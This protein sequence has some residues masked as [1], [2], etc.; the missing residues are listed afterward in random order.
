MKSSLI[1]VGKALRYNLPFLTYI[2]STISKH[3]T[4]PDQ[5]VYID[6]NDK[7]LF[8]VLEESIAHADEIVIV[9]SNDSFNLVNKV[10]A[11][12]GEETLEVKEGML[13]P[14]KTVMFEPNSY[15]LERS[16]KRINVIKATENKK[17]PT[18]LIDNKN[19]SA[20]FSIINIDEDSLKILLEPLAQNYEIRITPTTIIDGWITVEAVSNKYGNLESFFKAAKSLLPQKVI[21][22]P[23]VI[24]HIASCLEAHGK[25]L[26]IAE[27]CTGGLI[28]SMLTE[29][30]GVSAV[31]KGGLVAYANEIKTSWLGVSEETIERHGA[32]SELCIREMLEG[33]LN[34]SLSDYAVATS[35]IAGPT[36]GTVEKPVGTVYVGARNKEGDVFIERLLLEGDRQYIQTQSAYH[37]FKLLLHV[38][39]NIFLK[40]EKNS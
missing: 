17:L 13:I 7:D 9:T 19:E 1:V 23:D 32:V 30:S 18:I 2:H 35:G 37:A 40:S 4:L 25:T 3:L 27:S 6:K 34:A 10:I 14:S 39:E 8:F 12:L 33:I 28:A 38:G 16:G 24:E 22:H 15:L 11:T 5:T 36:G 20:L 21:N 29:H 31:F 26:S